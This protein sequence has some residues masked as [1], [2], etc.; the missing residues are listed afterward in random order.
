MRFGFF[1]IFLLG[2]FPIKAQPN[3]VPNG[4]FETLTTCPN[5]QGQLSYASPW[6]PLA[7]TPDLYNTCVT[8]GPCTVP[9]NWTGWQMPH[10]GN[11]YAGLAGFA[12]TFGSNA[13]D[14]IEVQ[15]L[16][17]LIGGKNY[18]VE[19]YASLA[20]SSYWK[21]NRLGLCFTKVAL[22][23]SCCDTISAPPQIKFDTTI[24]FQDTTNWVRISGT[25]L[26]LGGE[27]FIT[28]GNFYADNQTD[29]LGNQ[30]PNQ[31]AYFYIDDVSVIDCGWSGID[32]HFL[33]IFNLSPNPSNGNFQLKGNFPSN[34]QLHIYNLIGEE[35]IQPIELPQGNQTVPVELNLAEG[36]YFYRIISRGDVLHEEKLVIVR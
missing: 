20:D 34:S 25:Y 17:T 18:C 16:D 27:H 9:Q 29:T 10:S 6:M 19:F 33:S 7:N 11:G 14:Y 3:L 13:R 31:W 24:L 22:A 4:G 36:I 8:T 23:Q 12:Y 5:S 28:I 35:I 21:I 32:S 1:M 30:G 26:A 2:F 15:L